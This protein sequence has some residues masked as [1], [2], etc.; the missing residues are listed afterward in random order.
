MQFVRGRIQWR[1]CTMEGEVYVDQL[2]D[3]GLFRKD[4]VSCSSVTKYTKFVVTIYIYIY[5]Y[6]Y[7]HRVSRGECARLRKNV[8]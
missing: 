2:S 7:T 8:P 6:I 3:Y 5:I 1:A 4:V